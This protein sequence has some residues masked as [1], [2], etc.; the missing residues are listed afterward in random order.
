MR[1]REIEAAV[2]INM[3]T[4]HG[5]CIYDREQKSGSVPAEFSRAKRRAKN[6][7]ARKSRAKNRRK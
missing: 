1:H 4:D 7:Q 3:A 6:K 5:A 2:A